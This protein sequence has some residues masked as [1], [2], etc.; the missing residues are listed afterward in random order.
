MNKYIYQCILLIFISGHA[1]ASNWMPVSKIQS[2][3]KQAFQL[4]SECE[5]TGEQCLDIGDDIG[6]IEG[7]FISLSNDWGPESEIEECS[8]EADCIA[9][10]Q[11][12]TCPIPPEKWFKFRSNDNSRVYC[13]EL[14][15]KQLVLDTAGLQAFNELKQQKE[16]VA[17]GISAAEERMDYGKKVIALLVYRNSLKTLNESQIN[18]INTIYA[19]IKGLLETGSLRTARQVINGITPDGVLITSEDKQAILD[20]IAAYPKL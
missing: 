18:Q 12:K 4:K 13:I 17:Q 6:A 14:I 8:S 7:G 15:G 10:E 1:S 20:K 16:L 5:K 3:S 9:K 19:P 2:Q 11:A